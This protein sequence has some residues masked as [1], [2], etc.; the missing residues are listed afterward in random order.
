MDDRYNDPN[1]SFHRCNFDLILYFDETTPIPLTS[2][3][4]GTTLILKLK[5][6]RQE[7]CRA[8]NVALYQTVQDEVVEMPGIEPG[9]GKTPKKMFSQR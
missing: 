5:A 6:G 7:G 1:D 4:W 2:F 8:P 3:D 9:S